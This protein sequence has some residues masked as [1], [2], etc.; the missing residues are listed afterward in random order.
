MTAT[1]LDLEFLTLVGVRIGLLDCQLL[2]LW[3]RLLTC[4]FKSLLSD[5]SRAVLVHCWTK[6]EY[7]TWTNYLPSRIFDFEKNRILLWRGICL[8]RCRWHASRSHDLVPIWNQFCLRSKALWYGPFLMNFFRM[9]R[10][11]TIRNCL[12]WVIQRL[13]IYTCVPQNGRH[14]GKVFYRSHTQTAS[15]CTKYSSRPLL[16]SFSTW[17]SAKDT[18]NVHSEHFHRTCSCTAMDSR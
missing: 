1:W 18:S 12:I 5:H 17:A 3:R 16:R 11:L 14:K 9:S 4:Q 10:T 15:K 8:Q 6:L 7:R 2:W 13:P